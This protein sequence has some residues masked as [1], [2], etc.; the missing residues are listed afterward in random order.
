MIEKFELIGY[1]RV[2]VTENDYS[3]YTWVQIATRE[4]YEYPSDEEKEQFC[5]DYNVGKIEVK[6]VEYRLFN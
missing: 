6:K 4:F 1:R 5:N 3:N 2:N